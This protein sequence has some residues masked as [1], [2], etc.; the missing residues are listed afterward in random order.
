MCVKNPDCVP[1]AL[2]LEVSGHQLWCVKYLRGLG[3]LFIYLFFHHQPTPPPSH[4][5]LFLRFLHFLLFLISS[6]SCL[7]F[8]SGLSFLCFFPRVLIS[9]LSRPLPFSFSIK[10]K[11]GRI[12]APKFFLLRKGKRYK[13]YINP[14]NPEEWRHGN[15]QKSK[16]RTRTSSLVNKTVVLKIINERV[17]GTAKSLYHNKWTCARFWIRLF[18][19]F[20]PFVSL[21][22][23]FRTFFSFV[24]FFSLVSLRFL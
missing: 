13:H 5:I 20:V 14:L 8:F 9:F 10:A 7:S 1:Q 23:F 24:S 15:R 17:E 16:W 3:Q 22:R 2:P 12:Q 21:I 18:L 19:F 6:V 11:E 4:L